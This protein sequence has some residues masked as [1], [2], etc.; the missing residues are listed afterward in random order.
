VSGAGGVYTIREDRHARVAIIVAFIA[1]LLGGVFG[2]LQ[3]VSRTPT[4]LTF[5]SP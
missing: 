4:G 3:V 2:V 1:L 5:T